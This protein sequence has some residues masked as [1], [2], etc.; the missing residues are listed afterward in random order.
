MLAEHA[1]H[2]VVSPQFSVIFR[3]YGVENIISQPIT[4][5]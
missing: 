2:V 3:T 5:H 4:I 1:E